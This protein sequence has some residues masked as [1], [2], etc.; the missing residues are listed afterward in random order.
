VRVEEG[1]PPIIIVYASPG[2][3]DAF[4][5]AEGAPLGLDLVTPAARPRHGCQWDA[6]PV[7]SHLPHTTSRLAHVQLCRVPRPVQRPCLYNGEAATDESVGS[8]N[9][10]AARHGCGEHDLGLEVGAV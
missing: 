2:W 9:I 7:D 6:D 5:R 8:E 10:L 4:I 3:I 1:D